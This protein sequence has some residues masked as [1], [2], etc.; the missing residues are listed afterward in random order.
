MLL[1]FT[2]ID[3][4]KNEVGGYAYNDA[5]MLVTEIECVLAEQLF[6]DSTDGMKGLLSTAK[7]TLTD[8]KA[9]II[10][11]HKDVLKDLKDA[12]DRLS[13]SSSSGTTVQPE[14]ATNSDAQEEADRQNTYRLGAIGVK[15]RVAAGITK[16]VGK[17]ITNPILQTTDGISFKSVDDYQPTSSSPPSQ[18]VQTDQRQQQSETSSST[19]QGWC[20]MFDWR[21][22]VTS[23]AEKFATNTAKTQAYGIHIHDDLKA[24]VILANVEW[25]ARQS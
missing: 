9:H 22:T 14:I 15:E 18:K 25:V 13:S 17:D 3:L 6:E 10:I 23:N 19:L 4:H 12:A 11:K 7:I 20:S 2:A 5:N 21:D 1:A 16:L 24:V 8:Y